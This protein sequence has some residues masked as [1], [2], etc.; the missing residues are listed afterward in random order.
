MLIKDKITIDEVQITMLKKTNFMVIF[1]IS[2]LYLSA[3]THEKVILAEF[4]C[5][6]QI[7]SGVQHIHSL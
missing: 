4:G 7:V 2:N 5:N 6:S 3:L 1:T